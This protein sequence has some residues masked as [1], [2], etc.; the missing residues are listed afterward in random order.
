MSFVSQYLQHHLRTI[1]CI[2]MER[3]SHG[4]YM[5]YYKRERTWTQVSHISLTPAQRPHRIL[6]ASALD[7]LEACVCFLTTQFIS[8]YYNGRLK[9][10]VRPTKPFQAIC[11]VTFLKLFQA[12][13]KA[14]LG[15]PPFSAQLDST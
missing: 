15:P 11:W 9:D 8:L 1:I 10:R 12:P 5:F 7:E 2:N 13:W 3:E 4:K 14:F 6:T